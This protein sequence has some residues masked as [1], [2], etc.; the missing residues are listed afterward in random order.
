MDTAI[1][2][3]IIIS[4]LIITV[5]TVSYSYLQMQDGALATWSSMEQRAYTRARTELKAVSATTNG[6][7]DRVEL[8]LRNTGETRM[9]DMSRWDVIVEYDAAT[10]DHVVDWLA[11]DDLASSRWWS[12]QGLYED[13]AEGQS[14]V[15]ETNILNAGEEIVLQLWLNPVVGITTTNRATIVTGNGVVATVVFTR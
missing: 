5:F 14:E 3:L 10:S 11:R 2:G 6:A 7:G 13:Y 15:F 4:L 8:A 1:S 9:A 12:V